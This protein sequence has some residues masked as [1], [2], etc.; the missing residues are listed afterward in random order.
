MRTFFT[1]FQVLCI[2]R[3]FLGIIASG[4]FIEIPK[5][6]SIGA[7]TS[8]YQ[9]EGAWNVSDK[10]E[11]TW[12]RRI[13]TNASYYGGGD[14]GDVAVDSYHRYKEDVQIIKNMGLNHYRFSISWSRVLPTGSPDKISKDGI[15]YYKNLI[16]ELLANGITPFVTIFHFDDVQSLFEKTGGWTDESIVE[17]FA[18]YARVL[19][20]ELGPRVKFWTTIN[21]LN[22]YCEETFY[23]KATE[24]NTAYTI[25]YKCVHNLLKAHARAYHIYNNEFRSSQGGQVGLIVHGSHH[26]PKIANDSESS[27]IAFNFETGWI[28]HPIFSKSGDYPEVMKKRIA[29][30]SRAEG[31]TQSRLPQFSPVW[32]EYIKG[33]AD[34]LG[35]NHYL[36]HMVEPLPKIGGRWF[37]DSGLNKSYN[38]HWKFTM[39]GFSI[40]PEG[41]GAVLR[42]IRDEYNNPP[43]YI[44]ENGMAEKA[45]YND[46]KRISYLYSFMREM[47][48][49]IR[50]G[51][52]VRAYTIWSLFD[53]LEW[54][55]GFTPFGLVHV[56]FNDPNRK[57]TPKLSSYWL[58]DVIKS[59]KLI[60]FNS[61]SSSITNEDNSNSSHRKYSVQFEILVVSM[62]LMM[63]AF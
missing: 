62:V 9:I 42:K 39:S 30:N 6:L 52:D 51:C 55:S 33:S 60:P 54:Y 53:N 12:D 50:D 45:E 63:Y 25:R 47:L 28:M 46:F 61:T 15:Q 36:T 31:L 48:L 8:A 17:Y 29:E 24:L 10:S 7:A 16:D 38:S 49:A 26:I 22:I 1:A 20:K 27:K 44:L 43:V 4:N 37:D 11:S 41:I 35:L 59:R 14:T 58:N 13:H 34:Y 57:R 2:S 56:D 21:E 40:V 32:I 19:F 3:D 5:G 23:I 18:D